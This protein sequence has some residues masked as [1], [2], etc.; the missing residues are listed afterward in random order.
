MMTKGPLAGF[1][2]VN[3]RFEL[4]TVRI[5]MSTARTCRS[6]SQAQELMREDS[7]HEA[8][9]ARADHAGGNRMPKPSK[10]RWSAKYF[11]A[12]WLDDQY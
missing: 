4:Q 10:V 5:T 11:L 2:V 6:S 1:P 12:P 3:F 8:C 9:P 7:A